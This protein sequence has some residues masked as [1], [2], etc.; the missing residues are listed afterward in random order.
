MGA[1]LTCIGPADSAESTDA[2]P[3][4]APPAGTRSFRRQ[5]R[6]L[7]EIG[8]GP[9]PHAATSQGPRRNRRLTFRHA[10][11]C[12]RRPS[13]GA[14]S[15]RRP[16]RVPRTQGRPAARPPDAD[17]PDTFTTGHSD[18]QTHDLPD[19]PRRDRVDLLR[20][21]GPRAG[22]GRAL[23]DRR[24][25][26][27]LPRPVHGVLRRGAERRRSRPRRAGLPRLEARAPGRRG[28]RP[29]ARQHRD[30]DDDRLRGR[31]AGSRVRVPEPR[32]P[33]PGLRPHD[34][35][36]LRPGGRGAARRDGGGDGDRDPLGRLSGHA[37]REPAR[38]A[39]G[40]RARGS[41]GGAAANAGDARMA[42]PR[43]EPRRLAHA[44]RH[45]R[46]S[47]CP[48]STSRSRPGRSTGRR[49]P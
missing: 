41:R 13:A 44:P 6:S 23:L 45:A 33:V 49:T 7:T 28:A 22:Q 25:A 12:P 31:G 16:W 40:D 36:P 19:H 26:A 43:R 24:A 37:A 17:D 30:V 20:R 35:G 34:V 38:G 14:T 11:P 39:R 42:A 3:R 32:V 21:H 2:F 18:A 8:G 47:P 48:R 27:R 10:A 15:M 4:T 1:Q 5:N 46:A 29:P 9:S